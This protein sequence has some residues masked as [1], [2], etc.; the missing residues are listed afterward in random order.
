MARAKEFGE[1]LLESERKEVV[2]YPDSE[3]EV[4]SDWKPLEKIVRG[5]LKE[6]VPEGMEFALCSE[7]WSPCEVTMALYP[8]EV[9][10][11]ADPEPFLVGD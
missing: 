1:G 4:K 5:Q 9:W 6:L 3:E 2:R 7:K 11:T 8:T 10:I